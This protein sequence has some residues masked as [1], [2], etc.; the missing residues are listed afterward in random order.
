MKQPDQA[1]PGHHST[2]GFTLI[3]LMVVVAIIGILAGVAFPAYQEHI[4]KSFRSQAQSC[5]VQTAHAMERRYATNLSYAGADPGLACRN[6]GSLNTRY[7]ITV[8][9]IAATTYTVTAKASGDQAKD[10]CGEMSL[11]QLGEKKAAKTTGCW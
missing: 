4:R 9:T 7:S 3:E 6:E 1:V 8:G 5:M 11:N 10:S 2:R